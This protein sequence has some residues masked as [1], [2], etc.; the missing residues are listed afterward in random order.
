MRNYGI[1]TGGLAGVASQV[2]R[3]VGGTL[4]AAAKTEKER[5]LANARIRQQNKAEATQL[6][7]TVGAAAGMYAGA[8]MGAGMGPWGAL[9]G[10]V[11]G[12][13]IGGLF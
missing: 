3:E 7:S 4:S 10:A 5:E 12:G 11:A 9:F 6:G 1:A 2:E 13:V 8:K